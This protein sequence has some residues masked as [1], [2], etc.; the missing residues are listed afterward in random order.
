MPSSPSQRAASLRQAQ[1][2]IIERYDS[3]DRERRQRIAED[4][5]FWESYVAR[6]RRA[7]AEAERSGQAP[8]IDLPHPDDVV[9]NAET[10][11][12]IIGP[13]DP[14]DLARLDE[15]CA[16]RNV[17]LMQEALD[18]RASAPTAD[19]DP[20]NGSGVALLFAHLL[21]QSV[22]ARFRLSDTDIAIRLLRHNSTPKRVLLK[23]LLQAWR[24]LGVRARRGATFPP[25]AQGVNIL[26]TL[27]D[28]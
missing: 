25:L 17:L 7:I 16:V 10:G 19:D 28:L 15:T 3:A 5:A 9:I 20:M 27:F 11:V 18:R 13:V 6:Q 14:E 1:K 21:N 8:P 23:A 24:S 2:H 26:N 12:K 4:V 22:P